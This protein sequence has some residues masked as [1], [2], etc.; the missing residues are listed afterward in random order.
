MTEEYNYDQTTEEFDSDMESI[1][2]GM[3]DPFLLHCSDDE[4]AMLIKHNDAIKAYKTLAHLDMLNSGMQDL[5]N[6]L[7]ILKKKH[8]EYLAKITH[9]DCTNEHEISC[10]TMLTSSVEYISVLN[11]SKHI[12]RAF[13][14]LLDFLS[15]LYDKLLVYC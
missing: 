7:Q 4:G 9:W 13:A 10:R 3:R 6:F 14:Q 15:E 2:E 1:C 8:L 12:P 5:A 11:Y